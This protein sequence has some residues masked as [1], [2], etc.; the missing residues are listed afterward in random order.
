MFLIH[1]SKS[2]IDP[3][4]LGNTKPW[5][6]GRAAYP[7]YVA[8]S[9]AKQHDGT[10]IYLLWYNQIIRSSS[11]SYLPGCN[12]Y[13][14]RPLKAVCEQWRCHRNLER[15]LPISRAFGQTQCCQH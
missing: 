2:T 3:R 5:T 4:M 12:Q 7:D 13:H 6:N 1:T 8:Q 11:Q 10:A 15:L 14:S 9:L